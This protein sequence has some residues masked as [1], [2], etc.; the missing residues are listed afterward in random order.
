MTSFLGV[1]IRLGERQLGQIYL[2]NKIEAVE[3]SRDDEQ[4]IETLAAYA[5]IAIS[6]W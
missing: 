5:G 1:P 6:N 2:T 3:F 4:V